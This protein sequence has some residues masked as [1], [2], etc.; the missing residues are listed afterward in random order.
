MSGETT[1]PVPALAIPNADGKIALEALTRYEAVRL[2]VDRAAMVLPT[3][4]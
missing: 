2:F 1:Y 4:D 3:F